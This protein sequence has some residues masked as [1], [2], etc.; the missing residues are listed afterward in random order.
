MVKGLLRFG[1]VC[2]SRVGF[3]LDSLWGSSVWG[4][5]FGVR[6]VCGRATFSVVL[7]SRGVGGI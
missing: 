3:G 1:V 2:R 5:W 7:R 4:F 6:F